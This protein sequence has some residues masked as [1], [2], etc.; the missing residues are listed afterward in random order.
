MLKQLLNILLTS[1]LTLLISNPVIFSSSESSYRISGQIIDNETHQSLIGANIAVENEF[2]GSISDSDGN[3]NISGLKKGVYSIKVS[4]VGYENKV[5]DNLVLD[6]ENLNIDIKIELFKKPVSI[7]GI[8]V[9][10]GLFSIMGSEPVAKQTLSRKVVETRPQFGEDIFRAVQRLPGL[11]SNDFSAKFNV[12]GGEQDEVLINIDGMELYEPFHMKEIDGGVF[13]I[14]DIAAIDGIDLMS[15]GYPADFGDRMSGVFNIK[16]K[17]PDPDYNRMSL[18]LS[19]LNTRFLIE[20]T[21]ADGKGSWLISGRKGFMDL[22]LKLAGE[23]DGLKP[24]YHDLFSKFVYK[25]SDNNILVTN[26]LYSNDNFLLQGALNEDVGDTL[27]SSYA[28]NYFWLTLHSSISKNIIARTIAS[29]SKIDNTKFVS[30]YSVGIGEIND[31][32]FDNRKLNT[33]GLKSD[34]EY[35]VNNNLLIKTGFNYKNESAEYDYFSTN[36]FYGYEPNGNFYYLESADTINSSLNPSSNKFDSYISTRF[37]ISNISVL[38]TGIRYDYSSKSDDNVISPRANLSLN[39]NPSTSLRLGWGYYYQLNRLDEID[40][41]DNE[42]NI[43]KAERAKHYVA[44]LEHK[45]NSGMKLRLEGFYKKYD[46]INPA[47]RNVSGQIEFDLERNSDRV[48]VDIRDKTSK[49]IELYLIND[50]G[51]KFNWWLSYAYTK[52]EEYINNFTYLNQDNRISE[53]NKILPY[54]YDQRHTI[55]LDINY[56]PSMNWQFNIAWHYHSGWPDSD[57]RGVAESSPG[58]YYFVIYPWES[59]LQPFKRLDLRINRKFKTSKGTITAFLEVINILNKENIRNYEYNM[60]FIDGS[61]R[62]IKFPEYW[63]GVMPSIGV[64]YNFNM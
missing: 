49:G 50:N 1:I 8:T 28:S 22:A 5:L 12:R 58:N 64:A 55:Y 3:F 26:F 30:D 31:Q 18:G 51:G 40:I 62:V 47:Y 44:G 27:K 15:G 24:K 54:P 17:T 36:N 23:D 60:E 6:E 33:F 39:F 42:S 59:H 2:V 16:T 38:E 61:P 32:I 46:R 35:E 4:H 29:I 34:L 53:N 43:F 9:T 45:F 21:F 10:P 11:T 57:V 48:K 25:L 52:V 7:K 63:L 20:K 13:S 37:R 19:F 56:R 41:K 14:V